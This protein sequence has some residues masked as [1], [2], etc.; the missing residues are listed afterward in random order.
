M[1]DLDRANPEMFRPNRMAAN[2]AFLPLVFG[3][4]SLVLVNG[5]SMDTPVLANPLSLLC[6]VVCTLSALM[7]VIPRVFN[8]GWDARY[9]GVCV[10]YLGSTASLGVVSWLCFLF[11]GLPPM[12]VRVL[13]FLVYIA[14]LI[15]WCFRTVT[16][17]RK[18]QDRLYREDGDAVYYM[19]ESDKR[20]VKMHRFTTSP[21]GWSYVISVALALAVMV[22]I[23][24]AVE[25]TGLPFTHILLGIAT[26]PFD[27]FT[28]GAATKGILLFY[29]YPG[30]IFRETGKKVYVDM[31]SKPD[32]SRM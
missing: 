16:F 32:F 25:L 18:V 27:M 5:A 22:V 2:G 20:L 7:M 11:F 30:R 9:F 31:T 10:L 21:N 14:V 12:P 23:R 26:L 8:W 1:R 17:Y 6:I 24:P 4:M 29:Y 28:L 3:V 15:V 13:V 19:Q